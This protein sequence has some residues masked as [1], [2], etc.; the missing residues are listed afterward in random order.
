[1]IR[2]DLLELIS[3]NVDTMSIYAIQEELRK[4]HKIDVLVDRFLNSY[5]VKIYHDGITKPL[6][7]N[8][9]MKKFAT[10]EK[11]LKAGINEL[12]VILN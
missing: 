9:H 4:K 2:Q 8:N 7:R 3:K 1:M 10:Y 11:A 6:Y 5:I 12:K